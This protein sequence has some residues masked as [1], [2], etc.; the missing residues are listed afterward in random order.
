MTADEAKSVLSIM[1][2]A[3]RGC[4]HCAA[5]LMRDFLR[6]WPEHVEAAREVYRKVFEEELRVEDD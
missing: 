4:F 3:D 6:R 1:A 5:E 2:G